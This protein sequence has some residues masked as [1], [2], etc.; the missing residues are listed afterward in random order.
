LRQLLLPLCYARERRSRA[1]LEASRAAS[2]IVYLIQFAFQ[3]FS[4]EV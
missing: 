1:L 2:Q 4:G 3:L